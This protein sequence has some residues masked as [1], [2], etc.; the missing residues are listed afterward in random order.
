MSNS[1]RND[2]RLK[3]KFHPQAQDDLQ[4]VVHDGGPRI[5]KTSPEL[6]W[7]K[8]VS[9]EGD[10]IF[11][12]R[13]LNVPQQ[14]TRVSEGS[15]IKFAACAGEYPVLVRDLYLSEKAKWK[16]VPC[17]QCGFDEL[18]DAP[19]ELIRAIFPQFSSGEQ[20]EMFTTFCGVCGGVQVVQA[21]TLQ[22]SS[23]NENQSRRRWWQFWKR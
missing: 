4:V 17:N 21:A 11:L 16:I 13:V 15:L 12:G 14:L 22:D 2:P 3:G 8:V 5:A 10:N 6:V 7:I 23:E 1:W 18:F 19:S 9:H 20:P